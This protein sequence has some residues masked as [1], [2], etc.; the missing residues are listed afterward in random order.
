MKTTK[1]IKGMTLDVLADN[2]LS[3]DSKVRVIKRIADR[4]TSKVSGIVIDTLDMVMSET[5][6]EDT[7]L[8]IIT[9]AINILDN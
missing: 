5:I 3:L 8:R 9:R 6:A 4:N 7:K 2:T 1:Q